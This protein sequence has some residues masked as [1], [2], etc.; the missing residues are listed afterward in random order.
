MSDLIHSIP[1]ELLQSGIYPGLAHSEPPLWVDG[2]N[3]MFTERSAQPMPGQYILVP[4]VTPIQPVRGIVEAVL[5][6]KPTLVI[7][8][9]TRV[10]SWSEA[11]GL[12]TLGTGL[13][14]ADYWTGFRWNKWVVMTPW[15]EGTAQI[16]KTD[17]ASFGD[18]GGRGGLFETA[19]ASLAYKQFGIFFGLD[20]AETK[21]IWSDLDNLEE[22]VPDLTN[23]A[24]SLLIQE[25]ESALLAAINYNG[26]TFFATAASLFRLNYL[27]PPL[28]FGYQMAV[29]GAGVFS[30]QALCVGGDNLLYGFGPSGIW[31]SDGTSVRPIDIPAIRDKVYDRFNP[32]AAGRIM[33]YHDMQSKHIFFCYPVG[34]EEENSEAVAYNYVD[35]NWAPS[36][37]RRT[38]GSATGVFSTP[39]LGDTDGNVWAQQLNSV[40]T[41]GGQTPRLPLNWRGEVM[42]P[43]GSSIFGGGVYGG[44]DVIE[45]DS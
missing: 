35:K 21:I 19:R 30:P 23:A 10:E 25:A 3:V 18:L 38:A 29:Q 22:F 12:D 41:A 39:L 26:F 27:G 15:P 24:G 34:T 44:R 31:Q 14:A 32:A 7:G 1:G 11:D 43:F 36:S 20:T 6:L 8:H 13:P 42:T 40:L 5:D 37:Q 28:Y 4:G 16:W 9:E 17:I 33:V 2:Q 45:G